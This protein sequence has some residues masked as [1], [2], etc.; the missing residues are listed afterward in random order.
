MA[1]RMENLFPKE[2]QEIVH[3]D[4]ATEEKHIA[5]IKTD[6]G[7]VIEFQRSS[8]PPA[9]I[10]KRENF[11]KNMVWVIDGTR[12]K[13]DYPRFCKG[14]EF[15]L[16]SIIKFFLSS[17]ETPSRQV[18][19]QVQCLFILIFKASILLIS[20]MTCEPLFGA[21]IHVAIMATW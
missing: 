2:W 10:K 17:L 20:Q 11:Y 7:F 13:R 14:F 19:V 9:E 8:I 12:L 15:S 3:K 5:D 1:Q 16:P 4:S 21:S 6:K 18:G